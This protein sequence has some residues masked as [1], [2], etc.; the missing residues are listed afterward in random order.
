[1]FVRDRSARTQLY[2]KYSK[3]SETPLLVLAMIMIPVILGPE[4]VTLTPEE[5][6]LLEAADWFIYACFAADFVAKLYLAPSPLRHIREN[7]LDVLILALPLLRPLRLVQGTRLL[8][9]LRIAR[10]LVFAGEALSKLRG[11]LTGRGLHWVIL[12]TLGVIVASAALVAAFERGAGGSIK[13]FPDAL[14]WAIT[15][16]T[17]VGY[18]DTYPVTPEGR[19]I[20]A[21]LMIV[22]ISFFGILTANIAAYFVEAKESGDKASLERKLDEV[23]ERLAALE[24]GIASQPRAESEQE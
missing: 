19:G 17:T 11:I 6:G 9:L 7:W 15:T 1:M 22:G 14:W 12:T 24:A 10:L 18:G 8:R 4:F 5:S 20:A 3:A 2:Q 13:E 21:F 23:L 16:V